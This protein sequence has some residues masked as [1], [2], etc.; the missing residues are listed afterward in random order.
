MAKNETYEEFVEKFKCKKTTDDCYTPEP[1]YNAIS[2][3]V[4]K[5][6]SLNG[7]D[8]IR[9]FCPD[10]D[11]KQVKYNN[12]DIVVDNPPFSILSEIV[13]FYVSNQIKFFLFCPTMTSLRYSDY[14]TLLITDSDITYENGARVN[15]S[16]ITNLEPHEIRTRTEIELTELINKAN[17]E[18]IG[19]IRKTLPKYC[20][21][22]NVLTA[23]NMQSFAHS[24]IDFKVPRSECLRISSL[25][26]QRPY[27][28]AIFGCGLLISDN[29]KNKRNEAKLK[30]DEAKLKAN[31]AKLKANEIRYW[32]LSEQEMQLIKSLE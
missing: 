27:K 26:S 25:E 13:K 16:F 29:L 22:D 12:T 6:Y 18:T 8:F 1:V 30:A 19:K 21:P 11:Y 28:K 17:E 10:K 7:S 20:Y 15:T 2:Q 31:E 14:C 32:E 23:S 24:G 5:Q 4:A 9:P 3:W